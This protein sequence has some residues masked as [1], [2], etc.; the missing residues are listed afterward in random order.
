MRIKHQEFVDDDVRLDGNQ[1]EH[2]TFTNCRMHFQ[3]LSPVG[4][5]HCTFNNVSWHFSGPASLTLDFVR[6]MMEMS[7]E[8]D[9]GRIL[10]VN[11][12][13]ALKDWIKPEIL[14]KFPESSSAPTD[15]DE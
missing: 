3:A 1:F 12:F 8:D 4:L 15:K 14:A 9:Y 10:F 13:P 5:Q 6:A 2:C 11:T 7:G